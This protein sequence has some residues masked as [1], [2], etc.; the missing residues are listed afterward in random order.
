MIPVSIL[1]LSAILAFNLS[2]QQRTGALQGS[3][4]DR[5]GGALA[6]AS[7]VLKNEQTNWRREIRTQEDGAF[8]FS[9][10]PVGTYEL[11]AAQTGFQSLKR[12]GIAVSERAMV[13]M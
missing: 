2:A 6:Q 8:L 5:S 4:T 13:M 12:T 1:L 10:V 7:L 11:T 3:V 9:F